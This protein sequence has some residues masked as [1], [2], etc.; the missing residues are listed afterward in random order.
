MKISAYSPQV[1]CAAALPLKER[2][3]P[4]CLPKSTIQCMFDTPEWLAEGNTLDQLPRLMRSLKHDPLKIN[5]L[6][7][8][9]HNFISGCRNDHGLA[10]APLD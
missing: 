5:T 2:Q 1:P 3:I 9:F 6:Q 4:L 8:S 10:G 7:N